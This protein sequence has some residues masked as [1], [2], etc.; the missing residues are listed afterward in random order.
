MME[1]INEVL[2]HHIITPESFKFV[3]SSGVREAIQDGVVMLEMSFDIRMAEYYPD[4]LVGAQM[5]LEAL[6]EQYGAQIDLRP[7]LGF[8]R[9]HANDPK[10]MALAH[11]AVELG[12][13]QSIDL[14][15]YQ[16]ACA[17]E[18]VKP[19][20]KKAREAGMKRRHTLESLGVQKK[21]SGLSKF[22]T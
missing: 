7:E 19:L 14:Y 11:E 2:S 4:A 12:V 5:F 8:P 15:S 17:P 10:L 3:A 13:F 16:E 9:T 21:S 1:Y 18:A 6:A 22:L 20:Y